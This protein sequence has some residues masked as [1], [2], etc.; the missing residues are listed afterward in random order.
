[1]LIV[2]VFIVVLAG[3]ASFITLHQTD[4]NP[5]VASTPKPKKAA[6]KPTVLPSTLTGLD[7][8]PEVNQRPVIGAMIE[9]SP[10]ARPQSGLSQAGVV[11]EAVAEGGVTRFLA[12]FQD[13]QPTNIGP[14]RSA[15]PYYIQ[16]L[17]GFHAAYAH[18][19]GSPDALADVKSWGV[20][21]L[22]QFSNSGAYH[23]VSSRPA[24]H[25]MYA[26]VVDL[27]ALA[28]KK[29]YSS[30]FQGFVRKK[31]APAKQP[32]ATNIHLSL[33][34]STY[35]AQYTYNATTNSYGRAEGGAAQV[36]ANTGSQLTPSVVIALVVPLSAGSR[37]AQGS[38]YSNYN[39]IGDGVAYVFQD[40][41][42]TV[43]SW[44]KADNATQLSF[45]DANGAVLKLNPGQTWIT[46]VSASSKVNYQ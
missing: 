40:G 46:A 41:T 21:D 23:R 33:S 26:S 45:T 30:P 17:Q 27:A 3:T 2:G 36:D 13:Q 31:P 12:L 15:R 9:N 29:G 5:I 34:S 44:H 14:V 35:N 28:T 20:Q 32:T 4:A 43:G 1:M 19:G 6:P 18:V 38:A 22:D 16:W 25:N 7:V 24:P 8:A 10:D 37:D 42:V 11:F 39:P